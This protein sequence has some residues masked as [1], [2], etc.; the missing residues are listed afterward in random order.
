MGGAIFETALLSEII[1]T[2]SQR[3]QDPQVYFWRTAAGAEVDIVVTK[4]GRLI[5]LEIKL[6]ATPGPAMARYLKVFQ[7]DLEE[8]AAPAMSFT[9]AKYGCPWRRE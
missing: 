7:K 5:P 2:I 1:K 4:G 3:G 6:S 8:H 9:P